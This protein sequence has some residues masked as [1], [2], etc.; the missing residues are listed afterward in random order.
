[1][2]STKIVNITAKIAYYYEAGQRCF[3]HDRYVPEAFAAD[4][5]W[6]PHNPRM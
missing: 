4:S 1:M 2:V 5:S 6:S 3:I